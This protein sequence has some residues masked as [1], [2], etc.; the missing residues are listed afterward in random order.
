MPTRV[1]LQYADS[2]G[3]SNP[4]WVLPPGTD[5]ELSSIR[6]RLNGAG[7]SGAFVPVAELLSS[8]GRIMVQART[9]PTFAVGDTGVV[10]YAPF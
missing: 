10:T 5:I 8:D 9:E 4:E 2:P 1:Q 7:A 3:A 6:V